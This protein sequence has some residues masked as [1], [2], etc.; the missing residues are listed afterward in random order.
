M[1]LRIPAISIAAACLALAGARVQEVSYG[2]GTQAWLVEPDSGKA[3]SQS[4]CAV[5]FVHWYEPEAGDSNRNQYL[6]EAL[7]LADKDGCVSLLVDTMWSRP[8]WF[9]KRDASRDLEESEA[10]I[11]NLGAALDYLLARKDVDPK[12][13]AYVG[14][15]FGAMY[16]AVLASRDKRVKAWALQAGTASFSDWFLYFP[17]RSAA[18]KQAVIDRLAPLDPVKYIANAS[19][20]LLQFGKHDRH[21]PEQRAKQMFEAAREPKQVLWYESGHGLSNEAVRDRLAWIRQQISKN[22]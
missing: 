18:E 14:H 22:R 16:G 3:R 5:L 20:L 13:V 4:R 7:P 19:P 9:R 11:R 10:Q 21:V 8:E 15:D 6:R 1:A 17:A 12:R 2:S